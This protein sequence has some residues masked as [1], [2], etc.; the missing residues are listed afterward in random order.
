MTSSFV[1]SAIKAS[2]YELPCTVVPCL[3]RPKILS[4]RPDRLR[5]GLPPTSLVV[6]CAFSFRSGVERK[7]PEA[8]I[9]AFQRAFPDQADVRLVVKASDSS[10]ADAAGQKLLAMMAE[11]SRIQLIDEVLSD[12]DMWRLMASVDVVLSLHRA[13]GFG[14]VPAQ[15][16][17]IGIPV[18]MTG[19]SAVLDFANDAIAELVPYEL[20]PVH[21]PSG[22]YNVPLFWAEPSLPVAVQHLQRLYRDPAVRKQKRD[23]AIAAMEAYVAKNESELTS[24][25]KARWRGRSVSTQDQN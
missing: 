19:W 12:E 16:L 1:A 11:D 6:F 10:F 14:L 23:H 22:R 3:L 8:A 5:W 15:A 20:V 9:K 2:G 7:N 17:Q 4:P 24:L 21:D 25:V 18:I 13:E